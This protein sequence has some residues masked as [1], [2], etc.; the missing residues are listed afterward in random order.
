MV[1]WRFL[2]LLAWLGFHYRST[3]IAP[4]GGTVRGID[5]AKITGE[6]PPP[7]ILVPSA[8]PR[9]SAFVDSLLNR[10]FKSGFSLLKLPALESVASYRG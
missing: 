10:R 3:E 7:S 5:K 8:S 1:A 4:Y 2:L 9:H 6:D